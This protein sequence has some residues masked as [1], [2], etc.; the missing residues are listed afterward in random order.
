MKYEIKASLDCGHESH[1]NHIQKT[2]LQT[3]VTFV[4]R[5]VDPD[6]YESQSLCIGH[7]IVFMLLLRLG[8]RMVFRHSPIV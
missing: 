6:L 1:Q 4:C 2:F 3:W 5:H 8:L 7:C